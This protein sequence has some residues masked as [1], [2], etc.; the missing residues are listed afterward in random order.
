MLLVTEGGSQSMSTYQRVTSRSKK[1]I[2]IVRVAVG[3]SLSIHVHVSTDV[4]VPVAVAGV[5]QRKLLL[6][7]FKQWHGSL[8]QDPADGGIAGGCRGG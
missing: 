3:V 8:Q 2:L 1:L 5:E 4:Y 6:H 7:I